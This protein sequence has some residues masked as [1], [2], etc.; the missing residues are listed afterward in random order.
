LENQNEKLRILVKESDSVIRQCI[1][2]A[3]EEYGFAVLEA[4]D[5]LE[6]FLLIAQSVHPFALLICDFNLTE[7][8]NV[9]F[10]EYIRA[11]NPDVKIVFAADSTD[12]TFSN[13]MGRN[14]NYVVLHK[15]FSAADLIHVV[16][17]LLV[18]GN[19]VRH[20]DRYE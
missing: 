7:D 10:I 19:S 6:A 2:N 16:E 11:L 1:T 13:F 5:V 9:R 12:S 17:K 4:S 18:V 3:L 14:T 15:P 20:I 8:M